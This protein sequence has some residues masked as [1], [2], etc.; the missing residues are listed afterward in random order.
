METKFQCR[1]CRNGPRPHIQETLYSHASLGHRVGRTDEYFL[2]IMAP[3]AAK[4][5][6]DFCKEPTP[7]GRG[8]KMLEETFLGYSFIGYGR[9]IPIVDVRAVAI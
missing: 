6:S 5:L 1:G 7:E 9:E 2:V 4:T 3:C 8:G